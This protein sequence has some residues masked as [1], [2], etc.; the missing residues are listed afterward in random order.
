[1]HIFTYYVFFQ[2]IMSRKESVIWDYF[3]PINDTSAKCGIC[4]VEKK[5]A[6]SS[7]SNLRRH[8]TTCHPTIDLSTRRRVVQEGILTS[9]LLQCERFPDCRHNAANIAD[10]LK[11]TF[12]K[13]DISSK[14]V[15]ITTDNTAVM[16]AAVRILGVRHL[17]CFAHTLNLLVQNSL[18]EVN[19]L[20]QK[21]KAV[22]EH[23]I[24]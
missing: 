13:W 8:M 12:E 24:S 6:I 16:V 5:H 15:A 17:G 4:K 22:V 21:V 1:M 20:Q 19:E 2:T 9:T 18:K 14:I 23:S 7:T 3:T 10:Y 11:K